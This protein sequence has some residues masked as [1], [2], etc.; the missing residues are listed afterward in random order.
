VDGDERSDLVRLATG[1]MTVGFALTDA[2]G[3]LREVNAAMCRFLGRT[4]S[5]LL[6]LGFEQ[7]LAQDELVTELELAAEIRDGSIDSFRRRARFVRSGGSV[8][9]GDIAV[10]GVRDESGRLIAYV[11][12]VVDVTEE[13]QTQERLRALID[14]MLD[15]WVLLEAMRDEEGRVVDFVYR[16]ANSAACRYNGLEHDDL[17]GRTLLE[18]LPGHMGELLE[19]YAAVVD[20]GIPLVRDDAP[21]PDPA[22]DAVRY[23]DNRGVRAGDAISFTWRDVTDRVERRQALARQARQDPLTGLANRAGLLEGIAAAVE[24]SPRQGMQIAV[25]YCDVDGLKAVNDTHG[26]RVGDSLLRAVADRM[27]GAVRR[28]DLVARIG[29]DEFV[30]MATGITDDE[31]ALAL[32]GKVAEAVSRPLTVDGGTMLLPRISIGVAMARDGQSPDDVLAAADRALYRQKR[33]QG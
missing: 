8:V 30:V 27:A 33:P 5:D 7:V 26:H 29:G 17:V 1:Q 28:D 15:P 13:V 23:F 32:A 31:A 21:Y 25:L 22:T 3:A 24:H 2:R 16:D 18:L 9:H 4:E 20:T 10:S 14:T 19:E 6:G 11:A 12:F